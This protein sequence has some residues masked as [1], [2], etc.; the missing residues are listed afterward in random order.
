MDKI[1]AEAIKGSNARKGTDDRPAE[2]QSTAA[3][4]GPD[5]QP[6]P[7][8]MVLGPDGKPYVILVSY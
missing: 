3:A 4:T 1:F 5:G 6:L 2:Q 7:P 8:G